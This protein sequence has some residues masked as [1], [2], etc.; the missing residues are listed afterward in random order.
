VFPQG[1]LKDPRFIYL[2][3]KPEAIPERRPAARPFMDAAIGMVYAQDA[4]KA[5]R[6]ETEKKMIFLEQFCGDPDISAADVAL[7][8]RA[9]AQAIRD[10]GVDDARRAITADERRQMA[11]DIENN[12]VSNFLEGASGEVLPEHWR[13]LIEERGFAA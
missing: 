2:R 5:A 13:S 4:D 9:V 10:Y 12:V 6:P 1:E 11:A 3:T 8:N 7:M